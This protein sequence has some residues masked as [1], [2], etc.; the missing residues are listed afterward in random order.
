M[1][2][3][4][5]YGETSAQ[6]SLY[7]TPNCAKRWKMRSAEMHSYM[8][9]SY[10]PKVKT[11]KFLQHG[12][13]LKELCLPAQCKNKSAAEYIKTPLSGEDGDFD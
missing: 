10:T 3:D 4:M 12:C 5:F 8:N 13:S 2:S 6:K 9:R 11:G 1:N 7:K